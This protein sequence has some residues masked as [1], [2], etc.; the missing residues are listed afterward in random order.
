MEGDGCNT[1]LIS[2]VKTV[3]LDNGLVC[4]TWGGVVKKKR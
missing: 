1:K 4:I 3:G 2:E